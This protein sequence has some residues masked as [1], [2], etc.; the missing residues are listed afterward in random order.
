MPETFQA[1]SSLLP[2]PQAR[3]L[4]G[5]WKR[6]TAAPA[7]DLGAAR[8]RRVFISV[9]S[10]LC[11]R[12]VAM[13]CSL[14]I[15]PIALHYL[16]AERYGIWVTLTS[17]VNMLSF[18]DFGI[19]IGLQ[20]RVAAMMGRGELDQ[21]T[22]CLRSTLLVLAPVAAILFCI[23][24]LLIL[25]TSVAGLV[26]TSAPFRQIDLQSALLLIVG[27][28]VL[29][30]PLGLFSRMALGL[31]Q[32]WIASV[33]TSSGTV[34][35][36][37]AVFVAST[38]GMGFTSFVALTVVPPIAAQGVSYILL[39]RRVPGGLRLFGPVSLHEGLRT[40]RQGS[41]YVLP[42]IAGVIVNQSPL[43][44]LGTFASP[45]SAATYSILCRISLPLQQLQQ[46]FLD[47]IWPAITEAVHRQ[48]HGWLRQTLRR[49]TRLNLAFSVL[50]GLAV[51]L[52]VHYLFPIL[53]KA[54]SLQPS[55]VLIA[56]YS[57]QVGIMCLQQGFAYISNS[58][59]RLRLQNFFAFVFMIYVVTALPYAAR[60]SGTDGLLIALLLLN[61]L[62][63]LPLFYRDYRRY[64][65]Q[66]AQQMRA[67]T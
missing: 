22:R 61:G 15:I 21:S 32:G 12:V 29:G 42:L 6:L 24:A 3:R 67:S 33:A 62:F 2:G 43:V 14:L 17:S 64:L 59:G 31:Q 46:M 5:A 13:G 40:L 50:A 48:D 55:H 28:F 57:A 47:Q 44:L 63:V 54:A 49:L 35:S 11:S 20:N 18:F 34:L 38:L 60:R 23:L 8:W 27:A 19:G 45:L 1:V 52:A 36:L 30:L 41:H 53:A 51:V 10:S 7:D 25:K 66:Q 39:S 4:A 65:E 56:L 26:F 16:G 58:L 37:I 9:G